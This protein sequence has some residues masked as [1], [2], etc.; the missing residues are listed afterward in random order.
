MSNDHDLLVDCSVAINGCGDQLS[1]GLGCVSVQIV[2]F[3]LAEPAA[4]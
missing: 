4:W 2:W 1:K 3:E